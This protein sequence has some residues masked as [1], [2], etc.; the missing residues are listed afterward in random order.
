MKVFSHPKI[1]LNY[2]P[3]LF[4]L[5]STIGKE[6]RI[7]IGHICCVARTKVKLPSENK[8]PLIIN[9]ILNSWFNC[10]E[11]RGGKEGRN[12]IKYI[13]VKSGVPWMSRPLIRFIDNK[14]QNCSGKLN[15]QDSSVCAPLSYC[16]VSCLK[17]TSQSTGP[18]W[19]YSP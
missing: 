6:L 5:H 12:N 2:Y 19:K 17:I 11:N 1:V 10:R 8:A 7:L 15:T 14:R 3:Q 4:N 13:E 16:T 18:Q 9:S